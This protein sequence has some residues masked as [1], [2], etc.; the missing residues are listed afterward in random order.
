MKLNTNTMT[1]D[2]FDRTVMDPMITTCGQM[3]RI[4]GKYLNHCHVFDG[5]KFVCM[6]EFPP[7]DEDVSK[8]L[9]SN[10]CTLQATVRSSEPDSCP[11]NW[12]SVVASSQESGT[13]N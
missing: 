4:G 12:P 8:G 1:M 13:E 3:K 2:D 9:S 11:A 5:H 7:K 10:Y 6:D